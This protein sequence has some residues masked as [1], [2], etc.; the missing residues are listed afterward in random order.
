[1]AGTPRFILVT[2]DVRGHYPA[3]PIHPE[4]VLVISG[5]REELVSSGAS[6]TWHDM[7]LHLIAR[8]AGSTAAQDVARLFALQ[9]HHDGL[10]PYIV[11][12][13][14]TDHGD[15]DIQRAQQWLAEHFSVANPVEEMIRRSSTGRAHLQATVRERDRPHP[16]RLCTA[17]AHR[18][19][20]AAARAD[21]G[22]S[23]RDQLARRLR[24]P[25]VLP[26]PV[27]THD[28]HGSGCLSKTLPDSG[29]RSTIEPQRATPCGV[30]ADQSRVTVG[31]YR[32]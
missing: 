9:W 12:E 13:G 19:C 23:R 4:R 18:G 3:V 32:K 24:R 27:Q 8:Y 25:R 20:E 28:R 5:P 30:T 26:P 22:S 1:M 11:F 14:K 16:D 10:T 29:V 2:P 6:A 15:A 17:A 7:V 21:G 31:L